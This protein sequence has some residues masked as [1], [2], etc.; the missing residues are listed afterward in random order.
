VER[1]AVLLSTSGWLIGTVVDVRPETESA[2]TLELEV[3]GWM[4]NIAGQHLDVRLTAPDGY[5]AARSYSV[6]TADL[7]QTLQISVDELPGGEVSPYLVH[8][9]AQGD[10]VEV[11]GPLGRWFVWRETQTEPIQLIGGGSGVVPLMAMARSHAAA[12]TGSPGGAAEMRLLYSVRSPASV[13]YRDEL[14][15]LTA[16]GNLRLDYLYTRETPPDW[17]TPP[18]R[19]SPEALRDAT[20]APELTPTIYVCGPTSFVEAVAGMLIGLGHE[21]ANIRTERFGGK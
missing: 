15:R 21:A 18:G 12:G 5:Q 11:R 7:G 2:K 14:E 20:I 8:G 4:G 19:V 1:G 13:F 3:P 16:S 10:K 6:A 17:P 9:L